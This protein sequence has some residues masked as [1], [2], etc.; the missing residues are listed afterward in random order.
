MIPALTI[1]NS[2]P[3]FLPVWIAHYR[4]EGLHPV[5]LHHRLPGQPALVC[6]AEVREFRHD[7]AYDHAWL[8]ATVTREFAAEVAKHGAAVFAE[9]DEFVM[10]RAL[11][12]K[13]VVAGLPKGGAARCTGLNVLQVA[14]EPGIPDGGPLLARRS[15]CWRAKRYDKTLMAKRRMQWTQGFHELAPG[16]RHPRP[17]PDLLLVH[18]HRLDRERCRRRHEAA[19]RLPWDPEAVKN[20]KGWQTRQVGDAFDA[21]YSEGS[22][23]GEACVDLPDWARSRV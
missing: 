18:C 19:L 5:V 14:G 21:W 12:L 15:K 8:L 3:F 6:D 22:D 7:L 23:L 17:C 16:E 4:R 2:E 11:P 9:A 20:G 1:V 13:A 10:H